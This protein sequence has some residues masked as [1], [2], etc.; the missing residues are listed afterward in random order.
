MLPSLSSKRNTCKVMKEGWVTKKLGEVGTFQRGGGF[1]KSD[2]IEGGYPC[3]HY[4]QI[5]TTFGVTTTKHLK[6]IPKELALSKSKIAHCGD[7]ILA[8]TSEDVEGSCKCTAWMGDYDVAVG[9]H[10]AIFNHSLYPPFVSYYFRGKYFSRAKER[11]AHGIKV[12]EIKPSDIASIDISFPSNKEQERI[13]TELDLLT[14]IIDKQKAQL[15]ELDILA[16]AIFYD[17]FG[18]PI[19]NEK[20]WK[21][22]RLGDVCLIERGGSPRP[23]EQ[24]ITEDKDGINWIKIG[25]ATDGGM[26]INSTKQRIIPEGAKKSR[27]V[28]KGDFL[29]SNSMS[30]GKPYILG[31]DGCI[32]DGWLVIRDTNHSFNKVY[33]YYYLGNPQT[34]EAFKSMAVGGVVSNLNKDMV[35]KVN[36]SIPPMNIQDLFAEKI[37][38]IESQKESINRSIV[39]SQKLFDYT[40]DKYFS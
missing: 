27:Y 21:L 34:Y 10:A 1:L 4:G 7:I 32:H 5:H 2:F 8:V 14:S 6:T 26:V 38:F 40:M 13:V 9:G 28:Q 39:E 12:V 20:G 11:Y 36:V 37:A 35:K 31:V 16:Q 19:E 22:Q 18:N 30:F 33:L 15:N 24:F 29:L 25:D 3:I 17:M 23:I